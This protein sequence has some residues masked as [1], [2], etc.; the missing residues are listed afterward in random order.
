MRAFTPRD[1][2]LVFLGAGC[3]HLVSNFWFPSDTSIIYTRLSSVVQDQSFD[4]PEEPLLAARPAQYDESAP[5]KAPPLLDQ[6]ELD[7]VIRRLPIPQ[8]SLIKHAPGW[9]ILDNLY[10]SNG[11]L[12]IVTENPADYPD[13]RYMTSTGLPADSSPESEAERMP[14]K[15]DLD[16]ITPADAKH[17]W[18]DGEDE[19]G[20]RVFSIN[21]NTVRCIRCCS[22]AGN[23]HLYLQL[24]FNDPDQCKPFRR[25][26]DLIYL[27]ILLA[28]LNH[29]YH[30][31]AELMF[32]AWTFWT[33]TFP[34]DDIN[35]FDRAFFP[36]TG[37]SWRDGPNMN[38]LFLRGGFPSLTVETKYD[39]EDRVSATKL[40]DK[41]VG[42]ETKS[43][44]WR[45][46]R[47]MLVDR[48][49]A[50]RGSECGSRTQR[51]AA[52]AMRG[53]V[54][55]GLDGEP[56]NEFLPRGWW[57]PV[58]R[59]VLRFVGVRPSVLNMFDANHPERVPENNR[60]VVSYIS[61]QS[62]RRRLIDADH[63]RLV[64][65]LEELCIRR[66]WELNIVQAEK[67][68]R[69]EQLAIAARTTVS[70]CFLLPYFTINAPYSTLSV[71]TEMGYHI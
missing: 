40:L 37:A 45:F 2:V 58:R 34:N 52:E 16:F 28:V 1:V 39:W 42:S 14:T 55:K 35:V 46:D 18:G 57:E 48:S 27:N 50:F 68:S 7:P 69:E 64:S 17:R 47:V 5:A 20:A 10:M 26:S 36:H 13:I 56:I 49:A 32:G 25:L 29:Y 54:P 70:S 51:T 61:R 67:L 22:K 11:T 24:L 53:V 4:G 38:S 15:Y 31:C 60:I 59:Q 43:R 71:Y 3:M 8:S 63:E 19:N 62:V 12:F 21:G 44:A 9:T 30:F 6:S 41:E 23:S 33:G 66:G 65:A